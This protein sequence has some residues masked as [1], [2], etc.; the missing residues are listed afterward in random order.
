MGSDWV[1]AERVVTILTVV[2]MG[3][4]CVRA[5]TV[6]FMGSDW[7]RA[8][9]VVFM[10]SYWVRANTVTHAMKKLNKL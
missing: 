6:V 1:S 4:D 3:S 9:T 7:V 5:N 2:F 8:N 10:G